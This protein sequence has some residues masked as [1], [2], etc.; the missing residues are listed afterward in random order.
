[1]LQTSLMFLTGCSSEF[2]VLLH[3]YY[4]ENNECSHFIL[5]RIQQIQV[6][7]IG[8][9]IAVIDA[10]TLKK[11]RS[12]FS[13]SCIAQTE[14]ER[15]KRRELRFFFQALMQSAVF[16]IALCC[17]GLLVRHVESR[18]ALF[19]T[20]TFTWISMH[21]LDSII[22]IAFNKELRPRACATCLVK[23]R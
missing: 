16:W 12:G 13:T 5:I 17:D 21:T 3:G 9:I 8:F 14:N 1:M 20:T 15:R 23:S 7:I 22:T 4:F 2:N 19:F 18:I 11:I 10:L 6:Y